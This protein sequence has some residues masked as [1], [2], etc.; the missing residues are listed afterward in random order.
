MLFCVAYQLRRT[1]IS[2]EKL[3]QINLKTA[4]M[5]AY[6]FPYK[7]PRQFIQWHSR[8]LKDVAMKIAVFWDV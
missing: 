7:I 4:T 2:T 1:E 3:L 6:M 5:R 8:V